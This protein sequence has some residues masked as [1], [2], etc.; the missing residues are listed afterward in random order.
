MNKSA[1]FLALLLAVQILSL[2]PFGYLNLPISI[3]EI[4]AAP[5][6]TEQS[7]STNTDYRNGTGVWSS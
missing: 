4:E 7:C 1:I 5:I 2:I 3:D 6:V